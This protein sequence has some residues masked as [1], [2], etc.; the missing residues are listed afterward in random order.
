MQFIL[1]AHSQVTVVFL[2]SQ[3]RLAALGEAKLRFTEKLNEQY[4]LRFGLPIC[5][6]AALINLAIAYYRR[7][8]QDAI[9]AV[10]VWLVIGPAIAW[11]RAKELKAKTRG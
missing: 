6:G 3:R 2:F 7:S 9:L 8:G 11:W 1:T 4:F 5:V 10:I